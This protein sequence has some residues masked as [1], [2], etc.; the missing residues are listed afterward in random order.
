LIEYRSFRN[1]DPPRII[2]LWNAGGLGQHAAVPLTPDALEISNLSQTY[3][4]AAGLIVAFDGT[5]LVGFVH[6]GFATVPE[7]NRLSTDEG[8]I[9][10][11]VVHPSHQ[12]Q[13][14]GR[15]L[16]RRAEEYLVSHRAKTIFAGPSPNRDPFYVG[17]Y[18]GIQPAGFLDSNT[19]ATPFFTKLGYQPV[20]RHGIFWRNIAEFTQPVDFRLMA[21]RRKTQLAVIDGPQ[22]RTW[23]WNSRYG[24]LDS[25]RFALIPKGSMTPL[26][27]VTVVGLDFFLPSWKLRAVGLVDLTVTAPEKD[28]GY[29]EILIAE[30]C[31]RLRQE[32]V[33]RVEI[34]ASEHDTEWIKKIEASGFERVETGTVFQK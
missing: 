24:G 12:G 2:A 13:G 32:L 9:C 25:I 1:G 3:F 27:T 26:A 11:V 5:N 18:G 30:V 16:V 31:K 17:I 7:Q 14:I 15:E 19:A 22:N 34:H 10:A 33:T 21:I 6:A 29:A 4:D 28:A 20:E 23:W 8:V